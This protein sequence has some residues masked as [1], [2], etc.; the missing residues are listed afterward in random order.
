VGGGVIEPA[1]LAAGALTTAGLVV[2][3][4]G[5]GA[6]RRAVVRRRLPARAATSSLWAP[7]APGRLTLALADADVRAEADTVWR[8]WLCALAATVA[9]GVLVGGLGLALLAA[10]AVTV[11]PALA[12]RARRGRGEL[13]LEA[14]LPA[15]LEAVARALRSGASLRQAV[16]EAAEVTPG[17]L[18]SEL[19][20]VAAHA[21]HGVPLVE[22]LE[23]FASRRPL[24]GVRLATAALCLGAETGGA[25]ARAVDGVADT[26]RERLALAAEVR[27]LSA[28][29][30]ASMVVIGLAPLGFCAFASAADDRTST[31]LFR[32]PLGLALL[33]AGLVLDGLGALWMRRLC[34]VHQ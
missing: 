23:G 11:A 27:A 8:G 9:A 26:L 4:L 29:T 16:A 18:G 32:T 19:G 21:D 3:R 6:G 34:R 1:G 14:A 5:R 20:A 25:E 33:T 31:F 28:Q 7:A 30:R 24:A 17:A 12:L 15:A 22:A 10:A 13:A 2:V